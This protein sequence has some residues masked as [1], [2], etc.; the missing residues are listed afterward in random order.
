MIQIVLNINRCTKRKEFHETT[1]GA[2]VM[3]T[4]ELKRGGHV[5]PELSGAIQLVIVRPHEQTTTFLADPSELHPLLLTSFVYE[6]M[7]KKTER[8]KWLCAVKHFDSYLAM[9][10]AN[11]ETYL[12]RYHETPLQFALALGTGQR[13]SEEL[14]HAAKLPLEPKLIVDAFLPLIN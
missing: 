13:N 7:E 5:Y 10:L 3:L 9:F 8:A 11:H 12:E 1:H 14:R 6:W 2:M 4:E